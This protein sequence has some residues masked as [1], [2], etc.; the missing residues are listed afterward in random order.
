LNALMGV[1]GAQ[2]TWTSAMRLP[3]VPDSEIPAVGLERRAIESS[4]DL[5]VAR[6]DIEIAA[7]SLGIADPYGWLTDAEIGLA[8]EREIEGGIWSVGPSL[9]L[10]IPLFD[11][12]QGAIGKAQAQLRQATEH[13]Y[14]RAVEIRS[15]VRAAYSVLASSHDRARYYEGV[16]VPLRGQ[17]VQ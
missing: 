3:A 12:G 1:W 9:S 13:F 5:A 16:I 17:L 11:Q 6:R 4:L 7:R 8:P 15:R 2:T 10:P 14:A